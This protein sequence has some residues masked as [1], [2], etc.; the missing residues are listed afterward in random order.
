MTSYVSKGESPL[1]ALNPRDSRE[2]VYSSSSSSSSTNFESRRVE[3]QIFRTTLVLNAH[4]TLVLNS[5]R[6]LC[7]LQCIDRA[8]RILEC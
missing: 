7:I 3:F 2:R 1:K 5:Q 6:V 8:L 4:L